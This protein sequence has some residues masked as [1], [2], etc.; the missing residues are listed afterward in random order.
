MSAVAG[1]V[2]HFPLR[3]PYLQSITVM[4]EEKN[5]ESSPRGERRY[6]SSTY[7]YSLDHSRVDF[8]KHPELYRV[9]R[10]EQGVLMV[11]PYKSELLPHWRFRTP[12]IAR[13]SSTT[14]YRMFLDYLERDD[15]VGA[16][17]ARKFIQ[18]GY[19]RARRYANHRSGR[20]YARNPQRELTEEGEREARKKLLLPN[21]EDPVKA[22]SAAIFYEM[23]RC[24]ESNER[25][26]QLKRKHREQYG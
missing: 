21:D 24:V 19:T 18:M 1:N 4:T 14:L 16:D 25:Y 11:E 13:E 9:G 2:R 20:K 3:P 22:E 15:F 10:G 26:A 6:R 23:W 8:R 17:M 7:D 12:E 5:P